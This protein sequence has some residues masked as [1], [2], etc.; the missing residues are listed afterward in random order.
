MFSS[1]AQ[2]RI[3]VADD[4]DFVRRYFR[5]FLTRRGYPVVTVPNGAVALERAGTGAFSLLIL[6]LEMGQPSGLEVI[7]ELRSGGSQTPIILMSGS[8]SLKGLAQTPPEAGVAYLTKPFTGSE[9]EA[10]IQKGMALSLTVPCRHC[11]RPI[12]FLKREGEH[13]LGCPACGELTRVT[14]VYESG[15]LRIRTQPA[16]PPP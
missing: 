3:L 9:L 7:R 11:G 16:P 1:H 5:D 14:A 10:A 4:D 12:P 13:S 8:F 2:E 6:D 15:E